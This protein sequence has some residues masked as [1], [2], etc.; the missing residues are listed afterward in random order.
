[1]SQSGHRAEVITVH[2]ASVP[3]HGLGHAE[4]VRP[5]CAQKGV[6]KPGVGRQLGVVP[7]HAAEIVTPDVP[8]P[9]ELVDHVAVVPK[10]VPVALL[11]LPD[12]EV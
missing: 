3:G 6:P 10:A 11:H 1:V 2:L 8:F 9:V 5:A 7:R 4:D 12:V